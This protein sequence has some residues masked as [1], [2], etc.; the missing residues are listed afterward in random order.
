MFLK[1][2]ILRGKYFYHVFQHRHIEL[3]QQDCLCDELKVELKVK[4]LYHNSKA[5]ELGA[6]F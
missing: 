1:S 2:M 5:I 3:M 6:K 4:S